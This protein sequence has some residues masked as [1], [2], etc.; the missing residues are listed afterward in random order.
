M[1]AELLNK[2]CYQVTPSTGVVHSVPCIRATAANPLPW[3]E[4]IDRDK[5]RACS[6][7]LPDGLPRIEDSSDDGW[8]VG[9]AIR[10]ARNHLKDGTR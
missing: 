7:C 9:F 8:W 2:P 6:K 10:Y 4:F 5:D 3:P 1:T